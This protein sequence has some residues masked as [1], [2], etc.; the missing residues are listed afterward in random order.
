MKGE[1]CCFP[2]RPSGPQF[3][4]AAN[5]ITQNSVGADLLR[6]SSF[7]TYQGSA[8]L[9]VDFADLAVYVVASTTGNENANF[10]LGTKPNYTDLQQ[11]SFGN[12]GEEAAGLGATLKLDKIG[13]KDVTATAWF[14]WGWDA[15]N[16][17][18]NAS[19]PNEQE[20]DVALRWQP[21]D[22]RWKGLSVW[23]RYADVFSR[24]SA[25]AP[26]KAMPS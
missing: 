1:R 10:P 6:V 20:L 26:A 22:G 12:A 7:F 25:L 18:T 5:L 15:I 3:E 11:L 24:G 19:L 16:P 14:V 4:L 8:R 2:R 21:S 17:T 13:L 23:A 9:T